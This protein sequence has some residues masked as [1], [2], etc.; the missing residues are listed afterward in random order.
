MISNYMIIGKKIYWSTIIESFSRASK[1]KILI[2]D[3]FIS[4]K[5]MNIVYALIDFDTKR[6]DQTGLLYKLIW[7]CVT[8]EHIV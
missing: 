3:S 5:V 2:R 8:W 1:K 4:V 6:K 7:F